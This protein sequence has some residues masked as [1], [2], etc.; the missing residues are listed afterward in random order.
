[1]RALVLQQHQRA[2]LGQIL[3][4]EGWACRSNVLQALADQHK[5]PTVSLKGRQLNRR[6]LARRAPT[7]WLL[8]TAVPW[9][10]FGETT[11]IAI[12][13]PEECKTLEPELRKSF[14]HVRFVLAD[15]EEIRS[16]IAAHFRQDLAYAASSRPS[17][18]LSCRSLM[19][20]NLRVTLCIILALP[21]VC[22]LVAPTQ[23]IVG[24]TALAL[25]CLALFMSLKLVGL[26]THFRGHYRNPPAE[27]DTKAGLQRLPSI[28]VMVP[29]FKEAEISRDLLRRLGRLSYPRTL[30][31]VFLVLE[32]TDE[33]T[34]QAVSRVELPHWI[35]VI[36][37]P[38]NG[39]LQT[40]P[41]AMNYALDFCRGDI[42]GVWDAEDAPEG[43]QLEKVARSFA[44]A[45]PRVACFQGVLDYYNPTANWLSRCFTLEYSGWFRIVLPA[46]SRLGLVLPLGGTTMFV[47]RSVLLQIG[48]WDAHNVTED[49][50]LGV[51]LYRAGYETRMLPSTT[52]EEANCRPWPWIKQRSRWLKGFMITY[53]VHMRHIGPLYRELGWWKL[54]GL[55]AFF[56][57][58][59][60]Q[61][62]LAP[63]LW[64]YWLWWFG[65]GHP[66]S[67]A[68]TSQIQTILVGFM[69]SCEA[70]SILLGVAAA[71][72]C[73][74][75]RLALCAPT[76]LFYYPLGTIAAY[77]ALY[78]L[79]LK[80]F[81]WDKTEHGLHS[82]V[83]AAPK[84]MHGATPATVAPV[85]SR[86]A[87]DGS[88]KRPRYVP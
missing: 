58:T 12:A 2:R 60:G 10:Q 35:K 67:S 4:A 8:H 88:Q 36:E 51:R 49:A 13:H 5:L 79:I 16:A 52:F 66:I 55:Q 15:E 59:I 77:K 11:I 74:R 17:N 63:V 56:I 23:S 70:L 27:H 34:R 6:L 25:L 87:S 30:L 84:P 54:L 43:D 24:I 38:P 47:R 81:Y 26:V 65:L 9:M 69:L 64:T 37:V 80:P 18:R 46:L 85:G 33:V 21:W 20:R 41:R 68:V 39:G 3:V 83:P 61:F 71:F 82:D 72:A 73:K 48:G 76:L 40:K 75:W 7:F 32:E 42:V 86:P 50:D 31:E 19:S 45:D 28:S 78:E 53:L 57:G 44:C 1:M 62:L 29:L 22:L 14:P